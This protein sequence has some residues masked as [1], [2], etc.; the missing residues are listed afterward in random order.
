MV[1]K[2]QPRLSAGLRYGQYVEVLDDDDV[3]R[4]KTFRPL[5]DGELHS[6]AL[7]QGPEA[8]RLDCGEVD[9][10]VRAAFTLDEAVALPAIEP[11]DRTDSAF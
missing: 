7:F 11:L 10:N 5:L 9:E 4:L 6:L 2:Q 8:V 1:G 3:S